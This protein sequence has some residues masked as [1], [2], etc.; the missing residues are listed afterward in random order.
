MK[1]LLDSTSVASTPIFRGQRWEGCSHAKSNCI[2]LRGI[3]AGCHL[4]GLQPSR[5][6]EVR[7]LWRSRCEEISRRMWTITSSGRPCLSISELTAWGSVSLSC[8]LEALRHWLGA[9]CSKLG[10][11]LKSLNLCLACDGRHM[12]LVS[13]WYADEATW[14]SFLKPGYQ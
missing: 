7:A 10:F 4:R 9:Q 5:S 8:F 3:C 12:Y 13:C 6:W 14:Y 1:F 11:S 2:S